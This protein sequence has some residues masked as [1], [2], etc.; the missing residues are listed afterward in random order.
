MSMDEE[1]KEALRGILSRV[2]QDIPELAALRDG[3]RDQCMDG[4]LEM[5]TDHFEREG[6]K[7]AEHLEAMANPDPSE[8]LAKQI[9]CCKAC[10]RAYPKVQTALEGIANMVDLVPGFNMR[11]WLCLPE[12]M[13]RRGVSISFVS[14]MEFG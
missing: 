6:D 2:T 5:L 14:Q 8:S 1:K 9:L 4:L 12:G 7:G 10:E 11:V 3:D 13:E